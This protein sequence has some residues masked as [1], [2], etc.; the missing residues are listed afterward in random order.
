GWI[1][2]E[3]P[4]NDVTMSVHSRV[5]G[6]HED[7]S[8]E[9]LPMVVTQLSA[10]TEVYDMCGRKVGV[11]GSNLPKGIYLVNGRKYFVK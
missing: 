3:H 7:T 8:I 11:L 2:L 1:V 10:D 6:G 9:S 5:D 4:I